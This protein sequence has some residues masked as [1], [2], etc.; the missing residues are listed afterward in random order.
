MSAS[1]TTRLERGSSTRSTDP[2]HHIVDAIPGQFLYLGS[3]RH[4]SRESQGF[5]G[6]TESDIASAAYTFY[7]VIV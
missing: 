1:Q 6:A 7:I 2:T 5:Q 4:D 3:R